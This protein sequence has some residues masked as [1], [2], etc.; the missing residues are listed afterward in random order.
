MDNPIS[1]SLLT[2][3]GE[4]LHEDLEPYL[5]EGGIIGQCL[6]HPLIFQVPYFPNA[7][8][9]YNQQYLARK[10][11]AEEALYNGQWAT[12]IRMHERPW[13]FKALLDC[14]NDGLGFDET[15]DEIWPLVAMVWA[16]SENI[17]QNASEWERL[18][19]DDYPNRH[20]AMNDDEQAA[21]EQ[22]PERITIYRGVRSVEAQNGM[23]WTTSR[24]KA[25]W[26]ANRYMSDEH[27]TPLLVVG[28]IEK[29]YVLAHILR[30]GE[31][32]IVA[33]PRHVGV[34]EVIRLKEES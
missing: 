23:S 4:P 33:C 18:W 19:T 25:V 31:D 11:K 22:L 20:L 24:T 1:T 9:L 16:D 5:F 29:Q 8:H 10:E 28:E 14:I 2:V 15:G 34:A 7:T 32:E 26:F 6:K 21:F 30:R 17:H 13:R 3:T 12:Y 27:N